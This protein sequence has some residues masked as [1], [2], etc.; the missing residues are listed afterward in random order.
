MIYDLVLTIGVM[1]LYILIFRLVG[2]TVLTVLGQKKLYIHRETVGFF[3]Y[4]ALFQ[5]VYVPMVLL[6]ARFHLLAYGWILT[7]V[8]LVLLCAVY[9]VTA[10]GKSPFAMPGDTVM[11][12]G[13][14]GY[15]KWPVV[16]GCAAFVVFLVL[17][18][19]LGWDTAFYMGNM[20]EAIYTDTMYYY[21]GNDGTLMKSLD[22]RYALSG[23]S[24]QFA[25]PCFL[26]EVSPTI[27]CYYGIRGLGAILALLIVYDFGMLLFEKNESRAYL[28]VTAF[29]AVN[30]FFFTY[31]AT[32]LFFIRRMNEAKGYCANVVLPMVALLLFM[33]YKKFGRHLWALLFVIC[34]GS[35]GASMSSMM[36]VPALLGLGAVLLAINEKRLRPVFYA[37]VCAL[38][39]LCY[40]AL[41]IL[42][43]E[44]ILVIK[45]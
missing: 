22:F 5:M 27:M 38:P 33:I 4:F 31:S 24:M 14:L 12:E 20:N 40:V 44:K 28:L 2:T 41:F 23:F 36:L 6:R 3:A 17:Q 21:N 1:L 9:L 10:G 29:L 19:Y 16:I 11:E 26:L 37:I 18:Q 15:M 30:M 35:V 25:I 7:L 42:N 8:I 34:L 39:N 13:L 43:H 45:L 32:S